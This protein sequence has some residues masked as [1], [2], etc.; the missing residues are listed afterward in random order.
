MKVAAADTPV[1]RGNPKIWAEMGG[2]NRA[3]SKAKK[4]RMRLAFKV[5]VLLT[6]CL[7]ALQAGRL[8]R[9]YL[10]SDIAFQ[11]RN[12]VIKGL[13][14]HDG[15][16]VY[17]ALEDLKRSNILDL[18]TDDVS[19]R[20][21]GFPWVQD[22]SLRKHL[23]G[24][25]VLEIH[26]RQQLCALSV[27]GGV[28]EIDGNG[29]IWPAKSGVS[30]VFSLVPP[31]SPSDRRVQ[32][33]V[34]T[35]LRAGLSGKVLGIAP[36]GAEDFILEAEGGWSLRVSA[37]TGI[38]EQWARF[39]KARAWVAENHPE[40]KALDLRWDGRVV[41]EPPAVAPAGSPENGTAGEEKG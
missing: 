3:G 30:G 6:A 33:L 1:L 22:F 41:L 4:R 20:L 9:G 12:I 2:A 27:P 16:P 40:R 34:D 38:E 31:L 7:L 13:D 32:R 28:Y 35:L 14:R 10:I 21:A 39:Q 18:E 26:E 25:V 37:F 29:K 15:A 11:V 24:T 8:A 23:P 17:S 19:A 5:A 36:G